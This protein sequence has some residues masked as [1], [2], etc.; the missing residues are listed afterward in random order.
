MHGGKTTRWP[1]ALACVWAVLVL[2]CPAPA[3][4]WFMARAAWVA[5]GDTLRLDDGSW[6]RLTG[7]DAPETGK[8]G[9]PGQYGAAEA[10]DFL[11]RAAEG[12]DVRVRALGRDRHGRILGLVALPDGRDAAEA[13]ALAGLAFYYYHRDHSETLRE[14][15][16]AAQVRT[17]DRGRGFW[18]RILSLPG[19]KRPWVGNGASRRAFP[20]GS[21]AAGSLRPERRVE[22]TDLEAVFRA[23]YCP[24]R[25]YSPWP[26]E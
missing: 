20:A 25:E 11:R 14:R 8:H 21:K 13:V 6:V 5:D 18:P 17:M 2:A 7:I 9:E 12:R 16:L 23:G 24:A 22:F 19:A 10:R 4:D 26:A 15:L 1:L 3:G